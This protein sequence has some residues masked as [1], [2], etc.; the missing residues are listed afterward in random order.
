MSR[1]RICR[2]AR[3]LAE[4]NPDATLVIPRFLNPAVPRVQ[5]F[6][7]FLDVNQ[8]TTVRR[9]LVTAHIT[10]DDYRRVLFG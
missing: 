1:T 7:D 3:D 8:L 5:R 6:P 9:T 2:T 4:S 10:F